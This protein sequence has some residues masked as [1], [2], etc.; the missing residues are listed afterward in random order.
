MLAVGRSLS[1]LLS[2]ANID[3]GEGELKIVTN[4]RNEKYYLLGSLQ[5]FVIIFK[6][7]TGI[8]SMMVDISMLNLMS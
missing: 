1:V 7:S 8:F 6:T 3:L 2:P 5:Q 4:M